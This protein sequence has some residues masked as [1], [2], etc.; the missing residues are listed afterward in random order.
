MFLFLDVVT[1][2]RSTVDE[3]A[4]C[5]RL[6]RGSSGRLAT[7]L[8]TRASKILIRS[9]SFS[10]GPSRVTKLSWILVSSVAASGWT[11]SL[12]RRSCS[13]R[14][15]ICLRSSLNC[16]NRSTIASY[17]SAA[18]GYLSRSASIG[19][20]AG[21]SSIASSALSAYRALRLLQFADSF[22]RIPRVGIANLFGDIVRRLRGV[23]AAVV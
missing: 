14:S 15:L 2:S 4:A 3:A 13:T 5:G 9:S 7:R 16:V 11:A 22:F 1:P 20:D 8:V 23:H 10:T 18:S 19:H 12:M 21:S 6:F 17:C